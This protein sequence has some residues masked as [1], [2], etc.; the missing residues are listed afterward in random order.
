MEATSITVPSSST[1][2]SESSLASQVS[3]ISSKLRSR[4]KGKIS[5]P[6]RRSDSVTTSPVKQRDLLKRKPRVRQTLDSDMR[7][8]WAA[9]QLG[10]WRELMDS[11]LTQPA[12]TDRALEVIAAASYDWMLEAKGEEGVRPVA[13]ILANKVGR[14]LEPYVEWFPWATARNKLE[15]TAV[16]LKEIAK[17]HKIFVFAEEQSEKIGRA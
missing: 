10:M 15:A 14:G 4:L 13:L 3:P 6:L 12:F 9:Y 17:Q 2:S 1:G 7:W 11:G 5:L 16:F 8:L